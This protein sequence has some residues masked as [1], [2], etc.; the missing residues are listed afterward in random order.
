MREPWGLGLEAKE[1]LV[2]F[3]I[4][5][6]ASAGGVVGFVA[7]AIKVILHQMLWVS[8]SGADKMS[9]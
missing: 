9:Q 7:T 8:E 3:I 5:K 6:L 4:A 2:Q 1:K